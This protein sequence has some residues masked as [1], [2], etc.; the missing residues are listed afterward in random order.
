MAVG[1]LAAVGTTTLTDNNVSSGV[2]ILRGDSG[3]DNVF[4]FTGDILIPFKVFPTK[5][6]GSTVCTT[7][8]GGIEAY[9]VGGLHFVSTSYTSLNLIAGA[10]NMTGSVS[11]YGYK[12]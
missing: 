6:A 9:N 5:F 7:P 2:I 12:K 11:V 4:G 8:T 1:A 3:S 10:G